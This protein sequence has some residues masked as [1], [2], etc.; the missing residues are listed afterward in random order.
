VFDQSSV[1]RGTIAVGR[2][3]RPKS[4]Q[5]SRIDVKL[6]EFAVGRWQGTER[7]AIRAVHARS[8]RGR[9][10]NCKRWS[11]RLV[12]QITRMF[13]HAESIEMPTRAAAD[14]VVSGPHRRVPSGKVGFV[15]SRDDS[16]AV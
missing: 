5:S 1:S 16:R 12:N 11:G 3:R 14:L 4:H 6:N 10:E 7:W 2:R 8:R 13:D 9:F 15:S